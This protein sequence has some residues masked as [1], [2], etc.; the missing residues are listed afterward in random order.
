[1]SDQ[2]LRAELA[3]VIRDD[4]DLI[5]QRL[6]RSYVEQYPHSRANQM[7]ASD[8]HDWTLFEIS[9]IASAIERDDVSSRTYDSLFGDMLVDAHNPELTPFVNFQLNIHFEARAIAPVICAA[10]LR[11]TAYGNLLISVFENHIQKVL[12]ENCQRYAEQVSQPRALIRTW[13]LMSGM[14]HRGVFL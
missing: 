5:A 2:R 6:E 13:D 1:M 10:T 11:D 3:A 14:A 9:E 12:T 7:N 8:I 4:R